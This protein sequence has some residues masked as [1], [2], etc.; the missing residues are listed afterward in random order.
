[1]LFQRGGVFIISFGLTR[2]NFAIVAQL[3][4]HNL[5]TVGVASSNLV[6]RTTYQKQTKMVKRFSLELYKPTDVLQTRD[7]RE[8]VQ[9]R[10]VRDPSKHL[11]PIEVD[12]RVPHTNSLVTYEVNQNGRRWMNTRSADDVV[13]VTNRRRRGG[14]YDDDGRLLDCMPDAMRAI[15]GVREHNMSKVSSANRAEKFYNTGVS[16]STVTIDPHAYSKCE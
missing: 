5:P 15:E 8:V 3:V 13:V 16:R 9:I 1:M 6:Y 11:F 12:V 4:E 14:S 10:V 7:G 2:W